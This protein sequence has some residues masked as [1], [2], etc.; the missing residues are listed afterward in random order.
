MESGK[1]LVLRV[2]RRVILVASLSYAA[3]IASLRW[4]KRVAPRSMND[5]RALRR[6]RSALGRFCSFPAYATGANAN[7]VADLILP[8]RSINSCYLRRAL[9]GW[10]V[11]VAHPLRH[12]DGAAPIGKCQ[13]STYISISTKRPLS[14]DSIARSRKW[15]GWR[16]WPQPSLQA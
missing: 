2:S 1:R 4:L 9:G 7:V 3:L 8:L 6:S 10:N 15:C 11:G 16:R 13:T 12:T 5:R 14:V